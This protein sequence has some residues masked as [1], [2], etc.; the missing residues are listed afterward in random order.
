[1]SKYFN[2][3]TIA[4]FLLGITLASTV[5]LFAVEGLDISI[6]PYPII[7]SG[8]EVKAEG[9]NINGSTYL[10]TRDV[11]NLVGTNVEFKD[12]KIYIGVIED[13]IKP[14][15]T[16][17]DYKGC[18][19][20]KYNDNIYV[21]LA[22]L[23]DVLGYKNISYDFKTN[24]AIIPELNLKVQIDINKHYTNDYI[25]NDNGNSCISTKLLEK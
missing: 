13:N 1:M 8:E 25:I 6:N 10:K 18:K 12:S 16:P 23:R 3:Q 22:E 21:P 11:A 19:A 5:G 15:L 9:Y 20:I 7:K 17:I 4:S 2:K 24:V 14:V